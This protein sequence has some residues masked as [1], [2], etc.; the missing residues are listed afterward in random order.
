[1]AE[2]GTP[3]APPG[4]LMLKMQK[5]LLEAYDRASQVW[6]ARVKSEVDLWSELTTKLATTRSF[7]EALE[8]YQKLVV[9]RMQLAT[10]DGKQLFDECQKI[11]SQITR[12]LTNSAGR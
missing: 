9:Q 2:K 5:D 1:M 7:P 8:A 6:L 10:A 11:T 3:T 12:S 4:D